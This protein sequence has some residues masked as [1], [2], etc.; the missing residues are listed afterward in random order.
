MSCTVRV[1]L[2][3]GAH[4]TV[5]LPHDAT[6]DQLRQKA[7][8]QLGKVVG[9]LVAASGTVLKGPHVLA[10]TGIQDGDTITAIAQEAGVVAAEFAF[11]SLRPDG[12][13]VTWGIDSCGGN[14]CLVAQCSLFAF[15]LVQGSILKT[16]H[17][18]CPSFIRWW[19]GLLRWRRALNPKP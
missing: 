11:A 18:G 7:Q 1:V 10:Q 16:P 8:K 13:V 2:L 14:S 12:S 3:S 17:K 6:V 15:F 4:A 19:L 9:K 5:T